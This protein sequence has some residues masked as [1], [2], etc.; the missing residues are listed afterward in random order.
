VTLDDIAVANRLAHQVLGRSLDELAPQTRRLLVALDAM[1]SEACATQKVERSEYRFTRRAVREGA[2]LSYEQVRVHLER[3]VQL[4]YVLAHHG[5]RGQSFEYEL[6]Y[7]G[8][9]TDGKPFLT[10]LID[11]GRLKVANTTATLGGEG[12]G[13]G[14]PY[15]PQTGVIP[16]PYRGAQNSTPPAPGALVVTSS[17]EMLENALP[18]T[19]DEMPSYRTRAKGNGHALAAPR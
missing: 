18:G 12:R 19:D 2:G 10:G 9:G 11:V 1:V 3:L 13:F 15:R 14:V 8:R 4:E 5:G 16:A 17:A 6:L 7:D